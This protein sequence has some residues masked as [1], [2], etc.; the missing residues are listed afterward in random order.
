MLPTDLD[1][2][3]HAMVEAVRSGEIPEPPISLTRRT[4]T[5]LRL[6]LRRLGSAGQRELRCGVVTDI[7]LQWRWRL[8]V[9]EPQEEREYIF[10]AH[11]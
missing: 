9:R 1:G 3:F 4:T 10:P 2:A 6:F 11:L 8:G 5:T 7:H